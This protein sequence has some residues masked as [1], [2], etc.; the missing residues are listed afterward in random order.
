MGGCV[1]SQAL[2]LSTSAGKA[3][4]AVQEQACQEESEM[5]PTGSKTTGSCGDG[6]AGMGVQKWQQGSKVRL[7]DLATKNTGW[8]VTFAFQVGNLLF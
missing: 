5:Q 1:N 8:P 2:P 4:P 3:A 7:P 6:R